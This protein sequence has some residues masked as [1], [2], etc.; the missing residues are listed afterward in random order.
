MN[1]QF[2]RDSRCVTNFP[3][4]VYYLRLVLDQHAFACFFLSSKH[5]SSICQWH[6]FHTCLFLT[7]SLLFTCLLPYVHHT[8]SMPTPHFLTVYIVAYRVVY[9]PASLCSLIT[10]LLFAQPHN[11]TIRSQSSTNTTVDD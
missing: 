10:R 7:F 4:S 6:V 8:S 1:R 3:L 5:L 9:T 11:E 2:T